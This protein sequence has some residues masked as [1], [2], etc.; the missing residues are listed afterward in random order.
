MG[1]AA[2]LIRKQGKSSSVQAS[3]NTCNTAAM[4]GDGAILGTICVVE[5]TRYL[6][7]YVSLHGL[8]CGEPAYC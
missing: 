5:A 6:Y 3:A 7:M 8:T 2:P 4:D 1:A